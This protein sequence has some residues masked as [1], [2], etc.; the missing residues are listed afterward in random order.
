MSSIPVDIA[1][2]DCEGFAR[3]VG[4]LRDEIEASLGDEDIC[5]LKKIETWGR[6][7][8][9][10]GALT[11]WIA[12]NPVSIAALAFGRGTRWV[13]MHHIGHR[14]YDHVPNVPARYTSK[15]FAR[16][17][18]RLIDWADWLT[19]EA[20]I[21]EHN[22]LHHARTAEESDPDLIEKNT[23]MIR[24]Y[25]KALRIPALVALSM[26]WRFGFYA[27]NAIRA[28]KQ[29][30]VPQGAELSDYDLKT[31]LSSFFDAHYWRTGCVPYALL[32]FA[33]FPA[34][35][36]AVSPWA[37]FSVLCNS[38]LAEVVTNV[39]SFLAVLPNHCGADLYRYEQRASTRAEATVRQVVSSTNYATG[40]DVLG[41]STLWL[42]LHIEHHVWPDL[43]LLQYRLAQPRLKALCGKYGV[44]Y[45]Q[46]PLFQR[47]RKMRDI[48]VGKASMRRMRA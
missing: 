12:P 16:G 37:A 32:H 28:W 14:A 43:P 22:V 19:P 34:L 41:A 33:L 23:E 2:I 9:L 24:R 17:P 31:M 48:V 20:W 5:H 29:R 4:A 15:V 10:L 6:V 11:S 38:I 8:T 7:G 13:L 30:G 44:S 26:I 47:V 18:R 25:P 46:E 27:P 3:E 35:F 1:A 40:S 42:N 36:L 45:A 39:H 21:Y